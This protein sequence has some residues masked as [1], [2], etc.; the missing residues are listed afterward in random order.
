VSKRFESIVKDGTLGREINRTEIHGH[1]F[2]P[3]LVK[4]QNEV[5]T[6]MT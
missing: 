5:T 4:V 1:E 3:H 6:S 2:L